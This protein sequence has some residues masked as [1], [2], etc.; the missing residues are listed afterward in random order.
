MLAAIALIALLLA[1]GVPAAAEPVVSDSWHDLMDHVEAWFGRL[2]AP[3]ASDPV[4]PVDDS[5]TLD[6]DILP[7]DEVRPPHSDAARMVRSQDEVFPGM[8][9]NG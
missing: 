8:D 2:V 5:G 6:Q 4:A 7:V 9:P 3:F 1:P